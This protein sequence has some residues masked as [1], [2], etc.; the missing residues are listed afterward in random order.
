MNRRGECVI[1]QNENR[2]IFVSLDLTIG[3]NGVKKETGPNMNIDFFSL[4]FT[5]ARD[6]LQLL[7][8]VCQKKYRG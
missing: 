8:M 7:L 5:Q 1:R 3:V 2:V 4:H 6:Q